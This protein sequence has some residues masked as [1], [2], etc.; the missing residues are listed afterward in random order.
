MD[1]KGKMQYCQHTESGE[2]QWVWHKTEGKEKY[3]L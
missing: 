3:D 2:L 1:T